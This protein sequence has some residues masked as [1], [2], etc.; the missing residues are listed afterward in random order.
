MM[1]IRDQPDSPLGII[2]GLGDLPVRVAEGA[3]NAGRSVY[4]LRLA[5]FVEDQLAAYPGE[6]VGIGE[7]G[8]QIR[9][10]KAAGCRDVVFAGNVQRPDF[11]SLKLD[12]RGAR[13]LPRVL[14]AARKGDD[15]LLRVMVD[16]LE[17]EGFNVIAAQDVDTGLRA[18]A[19]VICGGM[20]DDA[21]LE[22]LRHAARIASLIG[23]HEIG[24]GCVVHEG[25]VLAVE[26][27]EGTD[28]M[29]QRVAGLPDEIRG[30]VLVKRPK[31]IQERRIDLP[32]IGVSTVEHA[33]KAGLAGIG[34]E[35][36]G[37]LIVDVDA[38]KAEAKA[39]ELFLYGFPRGWD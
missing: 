8:R 38:V 6:T 34:L 19:G 5:G 37:A 20:P 12:L 27:Q 29:L 32:T 35:E 9:M 28:G 7:T 11:A 4:I 24:Q 17:S 31:P 3:V 2:A 16:M 14:A 36:N 10:L 1:A 18:P 30:G 33:A 25:L 15:A 23:Q 39:C 22:D 13:L 26:A 21:Q